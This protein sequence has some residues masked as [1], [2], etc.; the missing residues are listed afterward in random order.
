MEIRSW[1]LARASVEYGRR[2]H[3]TVRKDSKH[4]L[5]EVIMAKPKTVTYFK[6]SLEDRPGTL[7]AVAK[8]LKAKKLGLIALWG[9]AA[10]PGQGELFCIPKNPDKFRVAFKSSARVEEGSGFFVRGDDETGALLKTLEALA[11]DGVNITA[12]HAIAAGGKFGS[13]IH[14]ATSD[15]EKAAESLGAK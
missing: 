6:T 15:L 11:D 14:V 4:L 13:F 7:L 8:E 1:L 9:Y 10:Q 3:Y 12:I 5:K 2:D